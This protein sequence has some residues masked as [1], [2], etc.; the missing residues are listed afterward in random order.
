MASQ[1]STTCYIFSNQTKFCFP[2]F[3]TFHSFWGIL[4]NARKWLW[5][6]KSIPLNYGHEFLKTSWLK[7]ICMTP[8]HSY[9]YVPTY[10]FLLRCIRKSCSIKEHGAH[11]QCDLLFAHFRSRKMEINGR[12]NSGLRSEVCAYPS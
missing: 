8:R 7:M 5:S 6:M 1:K 12:F 3:K 9:Y 11:N 10:L 4:I 2:I